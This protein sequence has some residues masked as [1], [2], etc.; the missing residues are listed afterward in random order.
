MSNY[1][2][3]DFQ[4]RKLSSHNFQPN[5]EKQLLPQSLLKELIEDD[6]DNSFYTKKPEFKYS[7]S[8]YTGLE[9]QMLQM[10][11]AGGCEMNRQP[12]NPPRRKVHSH[13]NVNNFY[14]NNTY[15]YMGHPSPMMQQQISTP[16]MYN[17]PMQMSM[18]PQFFRHSQQYD[19]MFLNNENYFNGYEQLM[20]N[21]MGIPSTDSK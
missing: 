14:N 3:N 9:P 10:N 1:I 21:R 2:T 12:N 20:F 8:S 11:I 7:Q 19:N 6:G 17:M 18:N 15:A 16:M 5:L 13:Q 4:K